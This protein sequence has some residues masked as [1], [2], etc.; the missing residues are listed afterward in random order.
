M[1]NIQMKNK[2]RMKKKSLEIKTRN[3]NCYFKR[4]EEKK[5]ST[6]DKNEGEQLARNEELTYGARVKKKQELKYVLLAQSYWNG[7]MLHIFS[8]DISNAKLVTFG[9]RKASCKTD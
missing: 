4:R 9:H 1:H 3:V 5:T 2:K 7:L 6:T 8:F